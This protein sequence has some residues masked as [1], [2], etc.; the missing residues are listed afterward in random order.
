MDANDVSLCLA[1]KLGVVFTLPDGT[2]IKKFSDW[3]FSVTDKT[4]HCVDYKLNE[5]AGLIK[6]YMSVEDIAARCK[7]AVF[8]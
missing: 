3:R 8:E 7:A 1:L 5:A 2:T 4:S 6:K